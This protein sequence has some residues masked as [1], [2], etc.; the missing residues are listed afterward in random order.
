MVKNVSPSAAAEIKKEAETYGESLGQAIQQMGEEVKQMVIKGFQE[1]AW[2]EIY[3]LHGR[4]REELSR[5]NA[6]MLEEAEKNLATTFFSEIFRDFMGGESLSS[7]RV[8][9]FSSNPV[10]DWHRWMRG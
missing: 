5:H 3:A 9:R 8:P 10:Q 2:E 6:R 7:K 4:W 1:K